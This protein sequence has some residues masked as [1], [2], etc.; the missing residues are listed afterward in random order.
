VSTRQAAYS[1]VNSPGVRPREIGE[2]DS[3]CIPADTPRSA[4]FASA[5]IRTSGHSG[6]RFGVI[7]RYVT[8]LREGHNFP[9]G[10]AIRLDRVFQRFNCSHVMALLIGGAISACTERGIGESKQRIEGCI[11]AKVLGDT[12]D[13]RVL[14][15]SGD[16][17]V[18]LYNFL[19]T[20]SGTH[21]VTPRAVTGEIGFHF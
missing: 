4:R 12:F 15:A 7:A 9:N 3:H 20:F 8:L 5:E 17:K 18:A 10:L 21:Y 2:G 13:A 11:E 14:H 1:L 6:T 16:D 19:S